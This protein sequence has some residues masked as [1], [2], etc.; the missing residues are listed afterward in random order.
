MLL[1]DASPSRYL[2]I[3][4]RH[5]DADVPW[6]WLG[7]VASS[8]TGLTAGLLA[9]GFEGTQCRA[10]PSCQSAGRPRAGATLGR[11]RSRRHAS[12]A[13]VIAETHAAPRTYPA[14]TSEA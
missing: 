12:K 4:K 14:S 2:R 7:N 3:R 5:R 9:P 11:P 1:A 13:A 6:L 10:N 8:P